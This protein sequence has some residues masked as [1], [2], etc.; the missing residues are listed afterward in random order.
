MT[1][2]RR[3]YSPARS[4]LVAFFIVGREL[5]SWARL[6]HRLRCSL[7]HRE[8]DRVDRLAAVAVER[9]V[10]SA[11]EGHD[12]AFL[13]GRAE[14]ALVLG[15]L[16]YVP[17]A[18]LC[19]DLND[20]AR[21]RLVATRRAPVVGVLDEC[22]EVHVLLAL[23]RGPVDVVDARDDRLVTSRLASLVVGQPNVAEQFAELEVLLDRHGVL[24]H[25]DAE[26]VLRRPYRADGTVQERHEP[27][28][29]VILVDGQFGEE[30]DRAGDLLAGDLSQQ[31]VLIRDGQS[32]EDAVTDLLEAGELRGS[33][34]QQAADA[35]DGVLGQ[36]LLVQSCLHAQAEAGE[37][38]GVR[39]EHEFGLG[40]CD[41]VDRQKE[42]L[43]VEL[44]PQDV[45]AL[46]GLGEVAE[47]RAVRVGAD[48]PHD[49]VLADVETGDDLLHD[50]E[51]VVAPRALVL[52][53]LQD[54]LAAV[55]G[56]DQQQ[57]LLV[58]EHMAD[59]VVGEA[60]AQEV[61]R[62]GAVGQL[63]EGAGVAVQPVDAQRPGVAFRE[64]LDAVGVLQQQFLE[65]SR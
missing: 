5:S 35:L 43:C 28:L 38:G 4:P 51:P 60:A 31:P 65:L 15:V 48:E 55:Y 45:G 12:V 53:Q 34:D 39:L 21:A 64:Q 59:E 37:I 9:G 40:A 33:R 57:Q 16:V 36:A 52:Q 11:V 26:R 44:T 10:F 61:T 30:Q 20:E 56:R 27:L 17:W 58:V 1:R 49:E 54:E 62:V 7:D 29:E 3:S 32:L 42:L 24:I 22:A 46:S 50:T 19:H 8:R 41:C 6:G 63:G 47:E 14:T 2:R 18:L 13:H 25:L 23:E